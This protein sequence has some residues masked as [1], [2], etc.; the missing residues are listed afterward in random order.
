MEEW[1]ADGRKVEV[2]VVDA[3]EP[4]TNVDPDDTSGSG[5]RPGV[6]EQYGWREIERVGTDGFRVLRRAE[7]KF[8]T[9]EA[10]HEAA[11]QEPGLAGLPIVHI[12]PQREVP[13][14]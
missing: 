13:D 4:E 5:Y 12:H 9:P 6:P 3:G 1:S 11:E 7:R 14:A 2:L 8:G 10:A